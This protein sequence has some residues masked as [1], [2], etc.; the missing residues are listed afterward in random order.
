MLIGLPLFYHE[1]SNEIHRKILYEPLNFSD[2]DVLSTPVKDILTKLLDRNPEK[3]FGVNGV[4]EIK[5]HPFFDSIDWHK[6][7]QQKLEPPLKPLSDGPILRLRRQQ[8]LS[9]SFPNLFPP[10]IKRE[11]E[12]ASTSTKNLKL[13]HKESSE[14]SHQL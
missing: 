12:N 4:S 1:D 7:L 9:F 8:P 10:N 6:L 2:P 11:G 5:I 13:A 14:L 3:R